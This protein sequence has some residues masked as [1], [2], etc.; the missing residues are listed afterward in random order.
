MGQQASSYYPWQV[1]LNVWLES[2]RPY[3]E[4]WTLTPFQ[5]TQVLRATGKMQESGGASEMMG[6][7]AQSGMSVEKQ[8]SPND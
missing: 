8:F 3:A 7:L 4:F 5:I 2:G 6:F 1:W